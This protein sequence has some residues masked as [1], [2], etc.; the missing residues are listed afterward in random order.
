MGKNLLSF[1]AL[2]IRG[3][4]IYTIAGQGMEIFM[5]LALDIGNT[6][7]VLGC[8]DNNNIYFEGR[9]ATDLGK[10]EMEYAV[11]FKNI[12]DI[13]NVDLSGLEGAILSSVVPP[14][15]PVLKNAIHAVTGFIP[16]DV[17]IHCNTG[18]KLDV[19]HAEEIGS[20]LIV[21]TV[22]ALEEYKPPVIIIDMGTATTFWVID[23]NGVPCGGAFMP[24]VQISQDALSA[25]TSQ[26]PSISFSD[27]GNV[28]G[29]NTVDCMKSGMIYGTAA[30]IDGMIE[31]IEGEIGAKATVLATGGLAGGIIRHCK[32]DI[33]FRDDLL[34]RGL[35]TLYEKN[36][37]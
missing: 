6:N 15:N 30:M 18:L 9:L 29:R 4:T 23:Q 27:L 20:D 16:L 26:L 35:W 33:I 2:P 21:A 3:L 24:G 7:I 22:A 37:R 28:I 19:D 5:I 1:L 25:R 31:R 13:Y 36:K 14:L 17:N 8:I 12:L 34:I 10:T 32:R 11:L